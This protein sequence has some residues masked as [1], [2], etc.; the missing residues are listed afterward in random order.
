MIDAKLWGRKENISIKS[1][2]CWYK[3]GRADLKQKY[4]VSGVTRKEFWKK[5]FRL[6]KASFFELASHLRP[7]KN[8]TLMRQTQEHSVSIKRIQ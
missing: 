3:A 1:R 7:Y 6:E 4:F 8:Q 5:N 2:T